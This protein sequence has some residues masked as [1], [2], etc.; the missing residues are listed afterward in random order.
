MQF[1]I[2]NW[3]LFL[4]LA[5]VLFLLAWPMLRQT[6]LGIRA[7]APSRAI[8]VVNHEGGVIV[9]VREAAEFQ[10][11]HIPKSM[12][13][14]LSVLDARVQDFERFKTKPV[15]LCC[16]SGNRSAKAAVA[17]RKHGFNIVYNLSGGMTAWHGDNLP[18]E[19]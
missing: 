4:A 1:V 5:V 3:Y 2:H 14:P 8:Q 6:M 9:D 13:L 11:G 12:N 19:R 15:V 18:L 16:Q 17:L 10:Q 7:V